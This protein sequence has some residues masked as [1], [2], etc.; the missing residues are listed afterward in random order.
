MT[1]WWWGVEKVVSFTV[2]K[3]GRTPVGFFLL[4]TGLVEQILTSVS[5]NSPCEPEFRDK[6]KDGTTLNVL[7]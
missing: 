4:Q 5:L 1:I 2:N 3:G 7:L 6:M